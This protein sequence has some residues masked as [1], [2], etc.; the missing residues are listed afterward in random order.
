[1]KKFISLLL[2]L[3]MSLSLVACGG[4]DAAKEEAPADDAATEETTDTAAEPEFI[5]K[6][7]HAI[8]E[9]TS[10]HRALLIF[11]EEV[12]KNS[13]GRISVEIYPNAAL[14]N[15]RTM[16]EAVQMGTLEM[17]TPGCFTVAN[18][19]PSVD[20]LSLPFLFPD[21]ETARTALAGEFGDMAGA[22]LADAN[23]VC[24]AWLENGIRYI[25]NNK[26][27]INT[28]DDMKDLKLRTVENEIQM[29]FFRMLGASPT[30]MSYTELFTGLQQG[31]VDA[32]ENAMFLIQTSRFEEVTDYLTLTAHSYCAVPLLMNKA[33]FDSVPADLQTVLKDAAVVARDAQFAMCDE[34]NAS[35]LEYLSTKMEVNEITPENMQKF[36]E[37]TAPAYDEARA[38]L[39]DELVDAALAFQAK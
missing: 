14:G 1:M 27:P 7:G 19:A 11:K 16:T 38:K 37:I 28:P 35:A 2:A 10:T 20:V 15:E 24:L 21:A 36:I 22:D 9:E 25:S 18:F 33:L 29:S 32:Q 39:G 12:E 34:D 8:Q 30:P 17:V 13:N 4:N 26:H 23:M 5:F 6:L 31:T 3:I